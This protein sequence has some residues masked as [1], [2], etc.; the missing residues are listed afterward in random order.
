MTV[1]LFFQFVYALVVIAIVL[2]ALTWIVRFL[3]RGR[4][5]AA[6]ATKLV[7]VVESTFL[8]QHSTLHVVKVGDRFFVVG[9]GQAG[10][11]LISE[12]PPEQVNEW[13]DSQRQLVRAQ[14]AGVAALFNRLK[15]G[16]R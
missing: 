5:L 9:G 1:G 16:G 11:T 10:I 15:G 4:L 7:S 2:F 12:L 13:I 3:S 6:T 8:T 14:R